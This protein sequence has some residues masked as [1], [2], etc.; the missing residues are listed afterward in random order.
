MAGDN[1]HDDEY[2]AKLLKEDAKSTAR[3]YEM[4][5]LDAFM[6]QRS[7]T[8]APKPNT[9]FLR[10]IIRQTDNHNAALLA[11]EAE[12]SRSRLRRMNRERER[13][14]RMNRDKDHQANRDDRRG[15]ERS[16][17]VELNKERGDSKR[18]RV[19]Y[20]DDDEEQRLNQ[21][22]RHHH[23][24]SKSSRSQRERERSRDNGRERTRHE[25]SDDDNSKRRSRH[26]IHSHDMERRHRDR[27]SEDRK[28]TGKEEHSNHRHRR[29]RSQSRSRS[30]SRS[31]SPRT[32]HKSSRG[33][34]T[35]RS[36][37]RFKSPDR[38]RSR[39]KP[40]TGPIHSKRRFPS[41][42]SDSDPLEAI[43]G[44]LPPLVQP[45]VRSRGRGAYKASITA[46][47]SRFS[48]DYN[49]STDV[50][51]NSDIEDDW[52]DALGA[53]KDR[54][55]W[56]QQGAERLKAAGFSEEQVRKWEKGDEK[57]EEDV[58]WAKRG[59]G[60]EWDRGKVVDSHGDVDL[61]AEWGRLT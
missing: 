61:K 30:I 3:K 46:M 21:R 8:G 45:P 44:P 26:S 52:D 19:N 53:L 55:R 40:T 42:D 37:A 16:T 35:P 29:R 56:K 13:E 28:N 12:D 22:R 51:I 17:P 60:R 9:N 24:G 36:P 7:R 25:H 39:P 11:K 15:E 34:Q 57:T 58:R 14:A 10:H 18:K 47:D 4:V 27:K 59:E 33:Q 38:R 41:P 50:H 31:P 49:P 43:V 23:R 20:S 1:L 6:P 5:G 32:R 2:V 48:T 54:E